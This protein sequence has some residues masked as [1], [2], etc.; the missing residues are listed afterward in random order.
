MNK[1]IGLIDKAFL[2]KKT[3]LFQNVELDAILAAADKLGL[4]DWDP[5]EV[6]FNEGDEATRMYFIATGEVDCG[7]VKL[8]AP[9]FFGDEALFNEKPRAYTA[10]AVTDTLLLTLTKTNLLTIIS[11]CPAVAIGLLQARMP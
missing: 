5:N 3:P 10:K 11:E 1:N 9:S 6:I 7:G 4:A 8:S 2:L